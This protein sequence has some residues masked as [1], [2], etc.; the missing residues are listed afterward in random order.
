MRLRVAL[1]GIYHETNT[2][3]DKPTTLEDFGDG[4][5]FFG[6][7]IITEYKDAYHEIGGMIEVLDKEGIDIVPVMF[8]QAIPGGVITAKTYEYLLERMMKEL[9]A[10]LPVD[11]CLIVPHGAGVSEAFEDMDGHWIS[12]LRE[13]VGKSIPIFGSFDPHANLSQLMIDSAN[14]LVAYKKNPHVDQRDAGRSVATLLVGFLK[15]EIKPVQ[16]LLQTPLVISIEQQYT[17]RDPC[18]SLFRY[19]AQLS[20]QPGVLSVSIAF[21][22]PYADVKDM[23]TS[24]IVITDDDKDLAMSI[25]KKLE[26]YLLEHREQFVGNKME[27]SAVLPL[28]DE[29]KKPLLLLD[30]GDNVGGGGPGNSTHILK[31]LEEFGFSKSFICLYDPEAVKE[32]ALHN[33]QESFELSIVNS[34]GESEK[35]SV[36]L[37]KVCDGKYTEPNPR[38][39]G[40]LNYDIG[41]I[42]IVVTKKGNTIMLT[43]L[44]A[45]PGSLRQLTTFNV[46]PESFDII[47]AKG[48]NAPIAAYEPV[49]STIIQV[50]TPGVTQADMRLFTYN[51]RRKPLYPFENINSKMGLVDE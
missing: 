51:N 33:L 42:A 47:V 32:A 14:G 3:L 19:A 20:E 13:K 4:H 5:W 50:N 22:F 8:A 46:N 16:L 40:Q 1:L 48:V 31:T 38:H 10:V 29:S 49:C 30:M 36:T 43:S 2:F 27:T 28:I 6:N 21:G 7:D 24:V 11:G 39:G 35:Y 34:V 45:F 17:E 44:R 9:E 18:K 41:R 26:T 15:K 12:I 23:G 37:I 25:G